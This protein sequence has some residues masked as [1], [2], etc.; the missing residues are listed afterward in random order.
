MRTCRAEAEAFA[1]ADAFVRVKF[2]KPPARYGFRI[3]APSAVQIA[4]FE[5]HCGSGPR[6]VIDGK[7]LDVE[8]HSRS[9]THP[10]ADSGYSI[11]P[12][13]MPGNREC[14]NGTLCKSLAPLFPRNLLVLGELMTT[15]RK[16]FDH[17]GD[18]IEFM[19]S[20]KSLV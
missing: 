17:I 9:H 4:A 16:L 12:H 8:N 14:E 13:R 2:Q 7:S 1:A 6:T 3:V 15:S 20:S 5:E 11:A 19:L 10:P 18:H